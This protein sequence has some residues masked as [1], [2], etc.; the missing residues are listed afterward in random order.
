MSSDG[1]YSCGPRDDGVS[2]TVGQFTVTLTYLTSYVTDCCGKVSKQAGSRE[3]KRSPPSDPITSRWFKPM[4][5]ARCLDLDIYGMDCYEMST[6]Y[7]CGPVDE[8]LWLWWNSIQGFSL[9]CHMGKQSRL[10]PRSVQPSAFVAQSLF[11]F[12]VLTSIP[13]W[14]DMNMSPPQQPWMTPPANLNKSPLKVKLQWRS[15][16]P[17]TCPSFPFLI[18]KDRSGC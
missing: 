13:N 12:H 11:S 9:S 16:L 15:S 7:A 18:L 6:V 5:S 1:I 17:S 4:A 8:S 14:L 3:R 2:L 10:T